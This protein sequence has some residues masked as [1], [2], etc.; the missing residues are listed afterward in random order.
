[1]LSFIKHLFVP[2]PVVPE[3]PRQI[4]AREHNET[5]IDML[6]AQKELEY[7]SSQVLMLKER[8]ERL[9]RLARAEQNSH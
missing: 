1:M 3:T 7:W 9:V 4:V 8:H 6:R 2:R 5:E